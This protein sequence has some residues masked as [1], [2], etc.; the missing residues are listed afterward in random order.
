MPDSIHEAF[1]DDLVNS[2]QVLADLALGITDGEDELVPLAVSYLQFLGKLDGLRV[3]VTDL[4][5]AST[6]SDSD[7]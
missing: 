2:V 5:D 3:L 1:F 6:E 7:F 4:V